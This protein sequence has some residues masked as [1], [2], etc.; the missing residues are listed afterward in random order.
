MNIRKIKSE[1]FESISKLV[2]QVHDLHYKNRPDIYND[3][4]PFEKSY[5]DFLM[6]DENTISIVCEIDSKIVGFCV[7]TI[8]KPSNN[9]L[10]KP[11]LVA[12]IEDMC[13]DSNYRRNGIGK[14]LFD[15]TVRLSKNQ[16]AT[17][18]ELMVWNFNSE[19][20]SFYEKLGFSHRSHIMEYKV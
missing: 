4:D 9:P 1:D 12:Y 14:K 13:V 2:L 6:N 19:A 5:F 11:R 18:V 15:E 16:G 10:L 3:I 20:I 17:S 7:T 8:R